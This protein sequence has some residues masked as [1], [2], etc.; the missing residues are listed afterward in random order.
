MM[1]LH[2]TYLMWIHPIKL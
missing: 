2:E 1:Y